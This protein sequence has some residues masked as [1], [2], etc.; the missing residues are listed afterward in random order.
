MIGK[1]GDIVFETSDTRILNFKDLKISKSNR[2]TSHNI[3]MKKPILEFLGPELDS[4]TFTVNLN[5]SLGI[6]V[7]EEQNKW[8]K[9]IENAEAEELLIGNK[10]I[11]QNKWLTTS[12][13]E[14]YNT[15]LNNGQVY[16]LTL[17]IKLQEYVENFEIVINQIEKKDIEIYV[18][19]PPS[20]LINRDGIVTAKIG[21]RIR[22]GPGLDYERIG[23]KPK[24][25]RVFVISEENGWY[26]IGEGEYMCAT[27]IKLV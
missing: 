1:Y 10:K 14:T 15:I 21:L 11:G 17:E 5:A 4:I 2:T 8:Y 23:V 20:N 3:L 18:P 12:I 16:S 26:K 7:N 24:G 25:E 27:Y 13:N 9:K 19:S 6:N 22:N